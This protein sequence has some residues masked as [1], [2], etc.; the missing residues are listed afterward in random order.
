MFKKYE[1]RNSIRSVPEKSLKS[2]QPG[3][4][5]LNVPFFSFKNQRGS[6]FEKS[7]YPGLKKIWIKV[8][9]KKIPDK[10]STLL[11]KI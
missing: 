10:N 11:N 2:I 1:T 7:G 6:K 8:Q 4:W 9:I 5:T 3:H